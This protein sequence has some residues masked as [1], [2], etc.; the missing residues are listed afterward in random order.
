MGKNKVDAPRTTEVQSGPCIT[1]IVLIVTDPSTI[2][3]PVAIELEIENLVSCS[4]RIA[5][6]TRICRVS[7]IANACGKVRDEVVVSDSNRVILDQ[8]PAAGAAEPRCSMEFIQRLGT[9]R[10]SGSPLPIAW[11]GRASFGA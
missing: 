3:E 8:R 6:R 1:G 5:C 9:T 7:A 11:V 10:P 2:V 4:I